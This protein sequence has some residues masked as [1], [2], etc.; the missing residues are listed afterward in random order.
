MTASI[1]P[2]ELAYDDQRR[3]ILRR[4]GQDD[5]IDA[6]IRRSFPWSDPGHYISIRNG[7]GK[8]LILIEDLAQLDNALRSTIE[9]E[10][11]RGSFVPKIAKI[12]RIIVD[13]GHQ[14]WTVQT[15]RGPA[16][17]RVQERE[18]IRFM[19]DG[20]F[21]IKDADGNVYEM[22]TFDQLD[23]HSQKELEPLI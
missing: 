1:P 17:F 19:N 4:P 2:F 23:P 20:R 13:L 16:K 12:D 6:R 21:R 8:E 10:L 22:A 11:A 9:S 3:L 14:E 18:D 15:D 5:V 7:E